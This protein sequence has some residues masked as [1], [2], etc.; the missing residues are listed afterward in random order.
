VLIDE[1]LRAVIVPGAD[2]YR[3]FCVMI[4]DAFREPL[5]KHIVVVS[6]LL[7]LLPHSLTLKRVK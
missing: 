6:V 3:A 5:M 2:E 1:Y 7:L 4:V